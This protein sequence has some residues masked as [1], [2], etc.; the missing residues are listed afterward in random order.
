MLFFSKRNMIFLCNGG[1]S[2]DQQMIKSTE[3][4]RCA[5]ISTR[6]RPVLDLMWIMHASCFDDLDVPTSYFV[7]RYVLQPGAATQEEIVYVEMLCHIFAS[8]A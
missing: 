2:C 3:V 7:F 8:F 6:M 1:E 4:R 5:L